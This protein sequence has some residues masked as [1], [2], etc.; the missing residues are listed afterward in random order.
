MIA[1]PPAAP[2]PVGQLVELGRRRTDK[3]LAPMIFV[4]KEDSSITSGDGLSFQ[5]VEQSIEF[6]AANIP[7]TMSYVGGNK[8]LIF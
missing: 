8:G 6:N 7:Y 2:P 1:T 3:W 4:L 5:R